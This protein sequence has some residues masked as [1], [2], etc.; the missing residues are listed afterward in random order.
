MARTFFYSEREFKLVDS[1]RRPVDKPLKYL[2][3]SRGDLLVRVLV[4][5]LVG[6]EVQLLGVIRVGEE[7][8]FHR[9]LLGFGELREEV[10]PQLNL[11]LLLD[12]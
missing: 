5:Q 3:L 7:A 1:V 11:I 12:G 9:L 6:D 4:Y 2:T 8:D 10:A